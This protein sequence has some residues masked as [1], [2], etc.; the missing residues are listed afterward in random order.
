MQTF[1][2]EERLCSKILFT[3]LVEQGNS[4]NAFPFKVIW[5]RTPHSGKYPVQVAISVAKKKFKKAVDRNRV[6]R[7]IREAY[8]KNKE[9][10]YEAIEPGNKLIMLLI[11]IAPEILSYGQ[12]ESKINE[13]LKR[14]STID[15]AVKI[16]EKSA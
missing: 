7:L 1:R 14:L 3:R 12:I 11:Y 8:R 10:L 6:K 9:V 5:L 13:A 2:K 16:S 15:D 4:F